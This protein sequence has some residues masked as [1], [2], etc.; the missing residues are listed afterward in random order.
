MKRLL[1]V[2]RM[3]M[4]TVM[5]LIMAI[6]SDVAGVYGA[7]TVMMM[8]ACIALQLYL[9]AW[10]VEAILNN[11]APA[12]PVLSRLHATAFALLNQCP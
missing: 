7:R 4:P 12:I 1:I 10:A 3:I 6:H 2:L 8:I 5:M 9:S 11:C